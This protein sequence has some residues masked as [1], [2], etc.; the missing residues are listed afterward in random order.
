[1]TGKW[2]KVVL[3]QEIVHTHP[4]QLRDYTDVIA[5]VKPL[6]QVYTFAEVI[7]SQLR[8]ILR[9]QG[10]NLLA[11]QG[12]PLL[13]FLEDPNFNLAR[14]PVLGDCTDDLDGN[15]LAGLSVY[16]FHDLAECSL[17]Q[18]SHGPV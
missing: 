4:Q 17:S 2:S 18:E 10:G 6:Q 5:M 13:E 11:V 8:S 16:G 1:M 3:L 14:V 15:P 9:W 7:V 12:I